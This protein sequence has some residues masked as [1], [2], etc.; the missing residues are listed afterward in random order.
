M[1]A[2]IAHQLAFQLDT[3]EWLFQHINISLND[4]LTGLIGRNGVGKS[5]LLSL[6][7]GKL[8]PTKGSVS[9]QGQA[10]HIPSNLPS[11]WEVLRLLLIFSVSAKNWTQLMPLS[12]AGVMPSI[13]TSSLMIGRS[14][15]GPSRCWSISDCPS[16]HMCYAVT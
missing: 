9:R 7:L 12:K 15:R 8:T 11:C 14:L 16:H 13:L 1:P 6:L 4:D 10:G 3:G 5:V 2:L